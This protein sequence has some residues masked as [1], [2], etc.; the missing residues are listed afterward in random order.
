M[1]YLISQIVF[2]LILAALLGLL[3]GWLIW[4][5]Y[6]RWFIEL[7]RSTKRENDD[8]STTLALRTGELEKLRAQYGKM[9]G[10]LEFKS[11]ALA[12]LEPKFAAAQSDLEASRL[13]REDLQLELGNKTRSLLGFTQQFVSKDNELA[14]WRGRFN[15][16]E[17]RLRTLQKEFDARTASLKTTEDCAAKLD[18]ELNALRQRLSEAER[19]VGEKEKTIAD[20]N[21]RLKRLAEDSDKELRLR[22]GE[23]ETVRLSL[24]ERDKRLAEADKVSAQ[25]KTLESDLEAKNKR[26]AELEAQLTNLRTDLEASRTGRDDLKAELAA[27]TNAL[28]SLQSDIQA[29]RSGRDDLQKELA[30]KTKALLS[31]QADLEASRQGRSDLE[32]ELANKTKTLLLLG[33]DL[34]ASRQGRD[35]LQAELS[36]KTAALL[37]A[38]GAATALTALQGEHEQR[39]KRV[40][41]LETELQRSSTR[42]RDLEGS[43]TQLR[44]DMEARS[45]RINEL[46]SDLAEVQAALSARNKRVNELEHDL[47]EARSRAERVGEL[48]TELGKVRSSFTGETNS[49]RAELEGRGRRIA[50]L[51]NEVGNLRN[52]VGT[53][54]NELESRRH[55]NAELEGQMKG[56]REELTK[57]D[58]RMS[59]LENEVEGRG[60][61]IGQLE[62]DFNSLQGEIAKRDTRINELDRHL[63]SLRSDADDSTRNLGAPETEV[64]ALR[65]E[66]SVRSQRVSDLETELS[67][68]YK[69]FEL[70]GGRI[71]ELESELKKLHL[72]V[73]ARNR[74]MAEGEQTFVALQ[75]DAHDR[76]WRI[77]ELEAEI[78]RMRSDLDVR[79]VRMGELEHQL[80]TLR[81]EWEARGN[82]VSELEGFLN[83]DDYARRR[84][85]SRYSVQDPALSARYLGRRIRLRGHVTKEVKE[86]A[87]SKAVAVY[88]EEDVID[89]LVSQGVYATP[90]WAVSFF[91]A[92]PQLREELKD[93]SLFMED[94]AIVISGV[95]FSQEE[96]QQAEADVKRVVG[97]MRVV[98]RLRLLEKD[99]LKEIKGVQDILEEAL[100]G[101]G[102][103]TFRQ[104]ATW[105]AEEV[106]QVRASLQQ[107]KGRIEREHWIEQ[108]KELHEKK[109][110]EKL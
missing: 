17:M 1:G 49:L 40:A 18:L 36:S 44:L 66:V 25:Y 90:E 57:R 94:G 34:Q 89:N 30:D 23:L 60:R 45:K 85:G 106:E 22:L 62:T 73:E 9:S 68:L 47:G 95:V 102:I 26:V 42:F 14:D 54:G 97:D 24:A 87:L 79:G 70:R 67:A 71:A 53:L 88:G 46:E 6:Q 5:R 13:G 64:A 63:N 108:S 32:A 76:Q 80:N 48:E 101:L 15:D 38:G 33:A 69:D 65:S 110:G 83:D 55:R 78:Q 8:L 21:S 81:G 92:A 4:G 31:L 93:G 75:Q 56:L 19:Q 96:Y 82:R 28:L 20:L 91:Q 86:F 12:D 10:D 35:D 3:L 58:W 100:H 105:T 7:Q 107:F 98:N 43:L 37:A 99:D 109:Y 59:E 84:L 29:G 103:F 77:G 41:E 104:I 52:E 50:E 61:R 51:E 74:A 11:K 39:G 16:A 2:C 72:E 27:K